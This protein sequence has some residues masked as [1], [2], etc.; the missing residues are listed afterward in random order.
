M[1][2]QRLD[3]GST[4]QTFSDATAQGLEA[5]VSHKMQ[6]LQ[7]QTLAQGLEKQGYP[8]ELALLPP[9]LIKQQMANIG[10]QR[11]LAQQQRIQQDQVQQLAKMYQ[12]AG[13]GGVENIPSNNIPMSQPQQRPLPLQESARQSF[14]QN[15][16][17]N[18]LGSPMGLPETHGALSLV[19]GNIPNTQPKKQLPRVTQ[20]NSKAAPVDFGLLKYA[21][22]VQEA[23]KLGQSLLKQQT[24]NKKQ[25]QKE[26]EIERKQSKDVRQYLA[27]YEEIK[28][29]AKKDIRDTE[30]LIKLAGKGDLR[31]GNAYGLMEKMGIEGFGRNLDTE[32]A[33][34]AIARLGQNISSA[35]G[36]KSYRLTNFLEQT[37]QRS[38]PSLWNTPQG[39]IAIA[40]TIQSAANYSLAEGK[41]RNDIIKEHGGEIPWNIDSLI[42]ER[43]APIEQ[44]YEN[45]AMNYMKTATLPLAGTV[46]ANTKFEDEETGVVYGV[47]NG[48][49]VAL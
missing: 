35:F 45:E 43:A 12:L 18:M 2:L 42:E 40:G 33:G 27:P 30:L 49:W 29:A 20:G 39:I 9:D 22:N 14:D 48:K 26:R 24:A 16:L 15:A 32:L 25:E 36:K 5:L 41:I 46:P 19:P 10:K 21:P 38:L 34:K 44:F 4:A 17:A 7:R 6:Q 3:L 31:A 47:K 23:T 13:G 8:R 1:A 37:F 11:Q 28:T